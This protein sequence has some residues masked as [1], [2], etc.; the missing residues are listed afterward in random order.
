MAR[1]RIGTRKLPPG[2]RR[3]R[4]RAHWTVTWT[5]AGTPREREFSARDTAEQFAARRP[6]ATLV[7]TDRF[8][9]SAPYAVPAAG[10]EVS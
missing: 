4:V 8:G 3:K 6:G 9:W 1:S 5:F 10:P 7:H 2:I